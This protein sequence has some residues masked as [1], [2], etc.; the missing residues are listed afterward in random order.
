MTAIQEFDFETHSV[1]DAIPGLDDD[2]RSQLHDA[3]DDASSWNTYAYSTL[4]DFMTFL[5][6]KEARRITDR[7]AQPTGDNVKERYD[8]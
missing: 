5:V 3:V 4:I 8:G 6:E 7:Q 2:M 1:I